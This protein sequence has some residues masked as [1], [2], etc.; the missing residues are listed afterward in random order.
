M[1]NDK[2]VQDASVPVSEQPTRQS[3]LYDRVAEQTASMII[4]E[5]S[6]SFGMAARLLGAGVRQD[7]ENIYGLVRLADEI[8]DGV[9]AYAG[10]S[11]KEI[12]RLLDEL[13]EE[14][15]AAM[16][17]GYSTNLVVHAFALTA[18][19]T[20]IEPDLTRPFFKSMRTDI[21]RVTHTPQSFD[22]YVYGSAEVVGLMCLKAF[23]VGMD[24]T[25]EQNDTFVTGARKLG[26][27]FQ[28]VNFLRDLSAD[29]DALGRSYFPGI[30]IATFTEADKQRLVED[31]D[32][33]L[34][35]SGVIVP[36]L[37]AS[38]RK[39]VA[40]AQ[41]LFA[42]LNRR[43]ARTPAAELKHTRVSVPTLVK[44][45]LALAALMGRVS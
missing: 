35:V 38:S 28:K 2:L 17:R 13:E 32:A 10:V 29:V 39:A 26:A 18:R 44:V 41:N 43:I 6:T 15:V 20:G 11:E 33:D 3:A 22:E 34:A 30:N 42:E 23:L 27:A 36:L 1:S 5:Y 37:P 40:L 16:N 12:R 25:P 7:V 19:R 45:R 8:V 4:R 9:A 24:L 14:T 31:I 21:T